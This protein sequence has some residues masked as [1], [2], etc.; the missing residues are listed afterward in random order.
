[1]V[2]NLVLLWRASGTVKRY[3]RPYI[4]RY[5][6]PNENFEYGYPNSNA[7]LQFCHKLESCKL[8]KAAHHQKKYDISNDVK[9]F[10][11]VPQDKLLQIFDIIKSDVALQNQV[12]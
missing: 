2:R 6:S 7:F 4:R 5:T 8:H 12:H 10:P 11:T 3:F 1:M 9:L